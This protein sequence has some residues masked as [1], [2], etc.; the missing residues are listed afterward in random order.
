MQ[1]ALIHIWLIQTRRPGQTRSWYLQSCKFHLRHYLN[2][3]RSIDSPKRRASQV[4]FA[5]EAAGTEFTELSDSGDSV[6]S[7]VS[8]RDLIA[9]LA[10]ELMPEERAVLECL[11]NGL[12]PREIGRKLNV[13]HTL[14]IKRRRKLACL[15]NQ[16]EA[17]AS[18]EAAV[19]KQGTP[20]ANGFARVN[21]Y[22][23]SRGVGL[24]GSH[25]FKNAPPQLHLSVTTTRK[26]SSPVPRGD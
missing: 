20:H 4:P 6:F 2:S 5:S 15:L 18:P 16:L 1:E 23:R 22:H 11:A 13:S 9:R 12:G 24:N 26:E 8:A 3:G 10:C 7:W 19:K 21:G 17:V 25:P 14:I